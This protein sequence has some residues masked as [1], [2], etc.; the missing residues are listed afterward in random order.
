[1]SKAV[2]SKRARARPQVPPPMPRTKGAKTDS[3]A[4][5]PPEP[6]R[7]EDIFVGDRPSEAEQEEAG[8]EPELERRVARPVSATYGRK[9][10][11]PSAA[12]SQYALLF[13]RGRKVVLSE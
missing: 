7:L 6:L 12:G 4:T 9:R 13:E 1:M 3:V 8:P 10:P 2:R 5:E 11:A